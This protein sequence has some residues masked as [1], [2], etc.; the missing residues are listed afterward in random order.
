MSRWIFTITADVDDEV[1][2][3]G[4]DKDRPPYGLPV[5]EWTASDLI[6]AAGDLI[7]DMD[8][9]EIDAIEVQS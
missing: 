7:V 3:D 5:D 1:L 9:A 8:E 4:A 2:G 6:A